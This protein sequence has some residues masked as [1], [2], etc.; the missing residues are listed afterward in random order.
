MIVM[1]I[2][3]PVEAV[4][5]LILVGAMEATFILGEF[6]DAVM[7]LRIMVVLIAARRLVFKTSAVAIGSI[8]LME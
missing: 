2:V 3:K 5:I 1:P 6:A 4:P 7:E 8:V